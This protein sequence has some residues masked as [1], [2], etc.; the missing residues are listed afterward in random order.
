M[1]ENMKIWLK[2]L[3]LDAAEQHLG[4]AS[5]EH[6]WALGS[7]N[8]EAAMLHE[9]NADENRAFAMILQ[10]MANNIEEEPTNEN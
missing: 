5:N 7:D 1:T 9:M 8:N 3:Y 4:A 10:S 2:K 6:L